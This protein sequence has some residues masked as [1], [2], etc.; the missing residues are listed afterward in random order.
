MR[1]RLRSS[2]F[3]LVC[4]ADPENRSN[5]IFSKGWDF[6]EGFCAFFPGERTRPGCSRVRP[7]PD[8]DCC[9]RPSEA[10]VT[11][12]P[13]GRV[14]VRPRAGTLRETFQSS[15][16]A[17]EGE[18][19]VSVENRLRLAKASSVCTAGTAMPPS[20]ARSAALRNRDTAFS[21]VELLVSMAIV[22][23]LGA[24]VFV[25]ARQAYASS[26][27]AVSANNIRQLAAGGM[28]YLGDH[29]YTFWRYRTTDAANG[30]GATWWFGFESAK[31]LSSAE[32]Q[33][34]FDPTK[35]PLANYVP[36]GFRPDPSFALGGRA[37]KPKYRNGY[38]GVGYN[39]LLGGGFMGSGML[40]RQ[41]TL[42]DPSQVVV[43]FTA[44]QINT[45]QRPATARN[46]M[47]E[48]FYGIDER[49]VT[50]HFR[51]GGKA[52]V[53]FASGNAGFLPMDEST[54]DMRSPE[55]NIGRF[56]PRGSGLFLE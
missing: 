21:L 44:A 2:F 14:P 8:V 54:R 1:K 31:S 15:Q 7:A 53:S 40:K 55:A 37:F 30:S 34:N 22:C 46:P 9:Q 4:E 38:I 51:H 18:V 41:M 26:S 45:F 17:S 28:A 33:R 11:A 43:F 24:I 6:D 35:G 56:A 32:G 23:V 12:A 47:L 39:T 48:E 50:A 49:E 27:L 19:S 20:L 52:M 3:D 13:R 29:E 16:E 10:F 5:N 36:K 42:A 25:A